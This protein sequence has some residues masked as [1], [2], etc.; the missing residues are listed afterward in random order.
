MIFVV[1]IGTIFADGASV[2]DGVSKELSG[3]KTRVANSL[4]IGVG[5]ACVKVRH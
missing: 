1:K 5:I 4:S 2:W 3:D